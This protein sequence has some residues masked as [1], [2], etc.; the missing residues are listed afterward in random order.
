VIVGTARG[1]SARGVTATGTTATAATSPATRAALFAVG[2]RFAGRA[3]G[4]R[5][6]CRSIL[7]DQGGLRGRVAPRRTWFTRTARLTRLAR[8]TRFALRLFG[9]RAVATGLAGT[10]PAASTPTAATV[11]VTRCLALALA[12]RRV[13]ARSVR[14]GFG[15][16]RTVATATAAATAA[17]APVAIAT[18]AARTPVIAAMA[19]PIASARALARRGRFRGF[20]CRCIAGEHAH[21]A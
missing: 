6:I 20:G 16:F 3:V 4:R 15:G 11:A 2:A 17:T 14:T 1:D 5:R 18:A 13:R 9:R 12:F 10:I 7:W 8:F 21:E 19:A